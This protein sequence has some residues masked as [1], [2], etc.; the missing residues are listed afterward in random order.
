VEVAPSQT[1]LALLEN[2]IGNAF[3]VYC[4]GTKLIS[5]VQVSPFIPYSASAIFLAPVPDRQIASGSLVLAI[6]VHEDVADWASAQPGYTAS[7]LKL[8]QSSVLNDQRWLAILSNHVF[9]WLW[10]LIVG[11]MCLG[12]ALLY[13]AQRSRTE[14]L[15]L[16]LWMACVLLPAPVMVLSTERAFPASWYLLDAVEQTLEPLLMAVTFCAFVRHK[17]G[18]R[19]EIL[20]LVCCV[21]LGEGNVEYW[22]GM[23]TVS[24]Y[25][26]V[27]LPNVVLSWLVLPAIVI[28]NV[29]RRDRAEAL[30]LIPMFLWWFGKAISV[31]ALVFFQVPSFRYWA[32]RFNVEAN[33]LSV[34]PI[35]FPF[36]QIATVLSLY[37]FALIILLRTNRLSRLQAVLEGEIEA[38]R[39]VQEV[40]LPEAV[41]TIPGF[42]IES[43]YAPARQ[44][45]GDFFQILPIDE[46]DLLL[47]IGDVAGKGLPAAMLVSVLVGA[48]RTAVQYSHSPTAMLAELNE[49]LIGRTHGGFSTALAALFSADGLVTI[50]NA[51]HLSP[52][53]DG[54]EL[55]LPGALPLGVASPASY[56]AV[57]L[58]LEPG[59]RLTF[60]SDGVIEAQNPK[61]ELFGFE[62]GREIS[63]QPA[64]VIAEAAKTFGQQ[65]DITVVAIERIATKDGAV[66][67][68]SAAILVPAQ[69]LDVVKVE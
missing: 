58:C 15:W 14:Y 18:L 37:S 65:D 33:P 69:A 23:V 10:Y 30:L 48:I 62:R 5:V 41:E 67:L 26:A 46:S 42:R 16:S 50:A 49:R 29:R 17:I 52:Y 9:T 13:S 64:A 19:L 51:G 34:G 6:R 8:G 68:Q 31:A 53:L 4:N 28:R 25:I 11:S 56:Q 45:G 27:A 12:S 43:V 35:I 66:K 39:Q 20:I 21:L 32:W 59:S 2:N 60:Y 3:E 63:T 47:V 57:Q 61:G 44:V 54:R 55:E 40:I 1:G 24:H 7:D 38:A 22:A 36:D